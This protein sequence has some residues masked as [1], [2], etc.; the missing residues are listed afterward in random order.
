MGDE[1][2]NLRNFLALVLGNNVEPIVRADVISPNRWKNDI[3][4]EQEKLLTPGFHILL[5]LRSM[6]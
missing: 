4:K 2:R 3:K 6:A 5:I 1:R